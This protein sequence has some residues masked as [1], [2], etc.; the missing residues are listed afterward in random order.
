MIT[1]LEEIKTKMRQGF[2]LH[3]DPVA[4]WHL[5]AMN[6]ARLKRWQMVDTLRVPADLVALLAAQG[7]IRT[8]LR[9]VGKAVLIENL[10]ESPCGKLN[11]GK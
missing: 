11:S 3:H 8:E 9:L 4:G 6:G 2:E 1:D 7:T 10:Q 5:V